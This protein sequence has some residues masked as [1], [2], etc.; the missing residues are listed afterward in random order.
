MNASR[1]ALTV[2]HPV[3]RLLPSPSSLSQRLTPD[4][5]GVKTIMGDA[6]CLFVN[7]TDHPSH[8]LAV[9]V[10]VSANMKMKLKHGCSLSTQTKIGSIADAL[11]N[12]LVWERRHFHHELMSSRVPSRVAQILIDLRIANPVACTYV[13]FQLLGLTPWWGLYL[14]S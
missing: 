12:L 6:S 5:P 9:C 10:K 7:T 11:F 4:S 13:S 2:I 1:R 3:S 8:R 14:V